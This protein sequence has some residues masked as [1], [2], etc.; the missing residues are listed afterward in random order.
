MNDVEFLQFEFQSVVAATNDFSNDNMLGR[1][2][3]GA[4]YKV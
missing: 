1:G 4:V 2:G 3:F